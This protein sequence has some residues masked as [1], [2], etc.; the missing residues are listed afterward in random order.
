MINAGDVGVGVQTR[1]PMVAS[2]AARRSN[3]P[4][5]SASNTVACSG[6]VARRSRQGCQGRAGGL[7]G[8][9]G[10]CRGR[11]SPLAVGVY[12]LS[13]ERIK[14]RPVLGGLINEYERVA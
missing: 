7:C 6:V 14:L 5:A 4:I 11:W 9:L 13:H 10:W 1:T 12:D 2:N 3:S 8:V